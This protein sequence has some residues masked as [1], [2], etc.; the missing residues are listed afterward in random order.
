MHS[1]RY[2][3]LLGLLALLRPA[4]GL[5]NEIYLGELP[6]ELCSELGFTWVI[7]LDALEAAEANRIS[8]LPGTC[9]KADCS[10]RATRRSSWRSSTR[11]SG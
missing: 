2:V 10:R 8:R 1:F 7:R 5:P 3:R 11:S 4:V 6:L 9:A